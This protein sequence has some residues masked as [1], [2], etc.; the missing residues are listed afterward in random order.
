MS[1]CQLLNR[2]ADRLAA[3]ACGASRTRRSRP[4][5]RRSSRPAALPPAAASLPARRPSSSPRCACSCVGRPP[6]RPVLAGRGP[7]RA[8]A[9]T[10]AGCPHRRP[11]WSRRSRAAAGPGRRRGLRP[12]RRWRASA[13]P[14]ARPCPAIAALPGQGAGSTGWPSASPARDYDTRHDLPRPGPGA[15]QRRPRAD[16][17][18]PPRLGDI[19]TRPDRRRQRRAGRPDAPSTADY[20]QTR[21]D[22]R[23]CS[24]SATSP[25]RRCP[26]STRCAPWCPPDARPIARPARVALLRRRRRWP[27][28]RADR[29]LRRA[30]R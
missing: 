19:D 20:A 28:V 4:S 24:P 15:H 27:T 2:A 29:R 6:C 3:G 5:S 12:P 17:S 1:A 16:R 21:A 25:T 30:L 7:A 11:S 9:A 22:R 14:P 26:R 8:T 13:S 18:A 10:R 23:R